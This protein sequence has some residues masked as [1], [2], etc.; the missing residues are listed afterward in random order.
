MAAWAS[1]GWYTDELDIM[2]L[3]LTAY[4]TES[5]VHIAEPPLSCPTPRC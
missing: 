3:D 1:D 5:L 2:A 4:A